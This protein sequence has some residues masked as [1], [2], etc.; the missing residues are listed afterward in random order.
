[1]VL[2]KQKKSKILKYKQKKVELIFCILVSLT[3]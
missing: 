1:M 3:K 2:L